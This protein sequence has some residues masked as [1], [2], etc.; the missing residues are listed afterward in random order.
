MEK[1][2]QCLFQ[3]AVALGI[4]LLLLA[5]PQAVQAE[6]QAQAS[7]AYVTMYRLYNPNSGEHL[8]TKDS[9]EVSVLTKIGWKKE[10]EAWKAA[11]SGTAVYRLYNPNNGDHHYTLDKNEYN[12]LGKIGWRKEGVAW[13]SD[14]N[15]GVAVY[16]LF[17]PSQTGAGSH[18][19]TT[20]KNEYKVLKTKGWNQEGISWYGVNPGSSSGTTTT[21]PKPDETTTTE[22]EPQAKYS[23]ELYCTST[24]VYAHLRFPVFIKTDNPYEDSIAL[25]TDGEMAMFTVSYDYD[26]VQYLDEG[27]QQVRKVDGGYLVDMLAMEPGKFTIT[28]TEN[29]DEKIEGLSPVTVTALDTYKLEDEWQYSVINSVIN[30]VTTSNMDPFEKMDAISNYLLDEFKYLKNDGTNLISLVSEENL[31]YFIKKEWDSYVS[32]AVLCQIAA[33]IGGFDEIYNCYYG[34][35]WGLHYYARLTIGDETRYFQACPYTDTN[36]ITNVTKINWLKSNKL[37]K[38]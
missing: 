24:T 21:N 15:K 14:S 3:L 10:G 27:A 4:A 7:T 22:P 26:D 1:K 17:N 37:I 13:Y 25:Y 20:D 34:N 33:K 19:Y 28:L 36:L 30:K 23:Y 35:D 29:I 38:L 31:P 11:K 9:N 6:E 32:P 5:V 12:T 2:K 18:H 16:R 8:Y